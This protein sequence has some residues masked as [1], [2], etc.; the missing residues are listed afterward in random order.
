MNLQTLKNKYL[1]LDTNVLI[2]SLKNPEKFS[3]FFTNIQ[4]ELEMQPVID[5]SIKFE[6]LRG[7]VFQEQKETL[8][9][10]LSLL[11]GKNY[12]ELRVDSEIF[13]TATELANIFSRKNSNSKS[14]ISFGDCLISAQMCR[15]NK[16]KDQLFL[17]TIDNKDFPLCV[18][19]RIDIHTID[20]C[21]DIINIG[22]YSFNTSSYKKLDADFKKSQSK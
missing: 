22:I 20:L 1:L 12:L 18:F 16:D 19:D 17:A 4:K 9:D 8:S 21:N 7:A 15:Y 2:N 3:G 6:F 14:Q 11:F 13:N 5:H 10:F